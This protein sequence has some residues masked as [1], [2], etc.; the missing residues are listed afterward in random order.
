MGCL[1]L[2]HV[3]GLTCGLNAA[4]V[5]GSCLTLIPRFD[6]GKALAV[7]G[8]DKVTVFEGVPTMYAAMLHSPEAAG[9]DMTSLRT[10][11]TGGSAM[12]VEILKAFEKEFGCASSRATACRRPRPSRR[13]TSRAARASPAPSASSSAAARC[14]SSTTRATTSLTV[15]PARSPS[16]ART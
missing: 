3:F 13:S 12:P 16:A 4:V 9:A 5:A 11:I 1:P 14:G 8:R 2:F 6:A 10:C 15:R 7:V